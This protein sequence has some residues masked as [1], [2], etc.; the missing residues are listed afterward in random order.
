MVEEEHEERARD[1]LTDYFKETKEEQDHKTE[2]SFFDKLRVIAEFLLFAWFIPGKRRK[3]V[4]E[5]KKK[6]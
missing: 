5:E 4:T 6:A 1:L 3:A 2:Y